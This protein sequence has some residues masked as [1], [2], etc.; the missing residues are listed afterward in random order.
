LRSINAP[1]VTINGL[2]LAP[3]GQG[4]G[5]VGLPGDFTPPSKFVR[6]AIFSVAAIPSDKAEEAVT[7]AFHILNQF[8][9]PVGAVR[10]LDKGNI[11][12]DYT[13]VTCVRDPKALRLLSVL[14]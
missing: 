3:F 1:P 12:S 11:L 6:A 2:T 7:Q 4:S 9:I 8:D 13:M 10:S 14:K 5:L